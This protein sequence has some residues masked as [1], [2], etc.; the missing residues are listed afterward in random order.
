MAGD[1]KKQLLRYDEF[2]K[3]LLNTDERGENQ[4]LFVGEEEMKDKNR[5][6]D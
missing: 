5:K 1:G 3:Q 2:C 4:I 6:A